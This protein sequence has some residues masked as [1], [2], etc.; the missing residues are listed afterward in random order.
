MLGKENRVT[1]HWSLFPIIFWILR[2]HSGFNEIDSVLPDCIDTFVLDIL[3]V[4]AG[5][6]EFGSEC[7]FF[8]G[9]KGLGNLVFH[10]VSA[11]YK[12]GKVLY[13]SRAGLIEE[14]FFCLFGQNRHWRLKMG[15][16]AIY[17]SLS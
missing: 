8:E 13:D 2:N 12:D 6:F 4:L 11:I 9:F 5:K 3:S 10:Q 17:F 14:R 16:Q 7:G 1:S 15:G